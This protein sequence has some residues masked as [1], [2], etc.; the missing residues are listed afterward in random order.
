MIQNVAVEE[1]RDLLESE[2]ARY[3]DLL[4]A[5]YQPEAVLLFGSAASGDIHEWSDLDLIIV[6]ET[7]ERFLDRIKRVITLLEPQVGVDIIVY[8]PEELAQL[9]EERVFVRD[10]IIAKSRVL[11]AK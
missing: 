11:Y 6:K 7:N 10:E 4:E 5:H 8:T 2:L 1:R 9:S 3:L